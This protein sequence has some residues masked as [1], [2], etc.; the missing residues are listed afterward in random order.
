MAD[1]VIRNGEGKTLTF[2]ITRDDAAVDVSSATFTFKVKAQISDTT[3]LINKADSSFTKT[4]GSNG[5]VTLNI[6]ASENTSALLPPGKYI[7]ELQTVVTS[8]TDVDRQEFSF[9]VNESIL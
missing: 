3:Y 5:I 7:A 9:I 6:P 1:I 4:G 8:D 2:T